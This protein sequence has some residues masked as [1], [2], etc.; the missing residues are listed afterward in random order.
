MA[1]EETLV[2]RRSKRS[3]AG[4]RMEAALAELAVEE[5]NEAEEDVDFIDDKDEEDVF[6][7]DFAS[8]DEEAA[9]GDVDIEEKAAEDEQRRAR[10]SARVRVEKATAA[11]HARQRVTFHPQ[12]ETSEK[13]PNKEAQKLKRRVS[14][15]VAVNAETGEVIEGG[16][17]Q[18][19]SQRSHTIMNTSATVN[20]MKDAE[21]KRATI[22]K[23]ARVV[24]KAP[25]QDELIA[26]ALDTEEGN[27][28]EHR[29]Y[30]K[31]EEEKRARARVVR[32]ALEGPVLR[33]ISRKEQV[34]VEVTPPVPAPYPSQYGFI[35]N[36][37][38]GTSYSGTQNYQ[39]PFRAYVPAPEGLPAAS[40]GLAAT[41]QP[42]L[43]TPS[44][45]T[46]S[47]NTPSQ[48]SYYYY[49][50]Q[51][52][53][54]ERV[55]DVCKNYIVHELS[56]D[57]SVAKPQWKDTMSAMFGDEVKWDEVRVFTGK[58]RPLSRPV[59]ACPITG[60]PAKYLDP[61]TNVPF[62]NVAAFKTLTRIL[63]HDY[64]WSEALGCYVTRHEELN[65]DVDEPMNGTT[66]KYRRMD[67]QDM[68]SDGT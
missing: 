2:S 60:T 46:P 4:N 14:L 44:A 36:P 30:L 38:Q 62:A 12:T 47:A 57:P 27:I 16:T 29:D 45:N 68:Q 61:R 52:P 5:V 56:Q 15:G 8:T 64:V 51:P 50:A 63:S 41:S 42:Q 48:S 53:A 10:R 1:E 65:H 31:L 49:P 26:R 39:S 66:T 18:R 32:T 7:S 55:D 3:T 9:A 34:K 54:Q 6:E 25:T 33:W 24:T 28:I 13:R 43:S 58:Q 40:H 59:R 17:R 35:Y 20:R 19:Q 22:P 21:E 11:A 23:K 37:H 67:N